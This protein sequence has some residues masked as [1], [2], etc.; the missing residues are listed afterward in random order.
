MFALRPTL[1][2]RHSTLK[3]EGYED[4]WSIRINK[5]YRVVDRRHGDTIDWFWIG[6][7]NDFDKAS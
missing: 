1:R 2:I 4:V 7:H 3:L 5:Q 6:T